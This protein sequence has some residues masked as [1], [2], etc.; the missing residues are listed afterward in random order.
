MEKQQDIKKAQQKLQTMQ[1]QAAAA[2]GAQ[3]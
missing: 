2:A 1:A 3:A